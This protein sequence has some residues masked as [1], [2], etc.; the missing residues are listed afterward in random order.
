MKMTIGL[1]L[2]RIKQMIKPGKHS[3]ELSEEEMWKKMFE[4]PEKIYVSKEAYDRLV[5]M[6]NRPP[7]PEQ[8]E[9]IRKIMNRKAPWD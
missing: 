4:N 7:T 2:N 9:S 3:N 8:I 1:L 6:I 5:E